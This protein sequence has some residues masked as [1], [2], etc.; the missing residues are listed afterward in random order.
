MG[1]GDRLAPGGDHAVDEGHAGVIEVEVVLGGQVVPDAQVFVEHLHE[2]FGPQVGLA[3]AIVVG[4]LRIMGA[5]EVPLRLELHTSGPL[6]QRGQ[7]VI[8]VEILRAGQPDGAEQVH[9]RDIDIGQ[10][11]NGQIE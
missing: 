10:L 5:I 2:E 8:D 4:P 3:V 1:I 9:L 6:V 7:G 11:F